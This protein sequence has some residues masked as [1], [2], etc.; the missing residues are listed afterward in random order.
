MTKQ[1]PLQKIVFSASNNDGNIRHLWAS[2]MCASP[3]EAAVDFLRSLRDD[4]NKKPN[5]LKALNSGCGRGTLVIESWFEKE[6]EK[7][8]YVMSNFGPEYRIGIAIVEMDPSYLPGPDQE[9]ATVNAVN[10]WEDM[11]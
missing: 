3:Q 11:K 7:E 5:R 2:K 4:T 6:N 10:M 8:V 1:R 9:Y